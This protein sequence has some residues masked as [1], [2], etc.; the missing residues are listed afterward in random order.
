MKFHLR[1]GTVM[2]Q[3]NYKVICKYPRNGNSRFHVCGVLQSNR[4]KT[5]MPAFRDYFNHYL[6]KEGRRQLNVKTLLDQ[7]F[8]NYKQGL[9]QTLKFVLQTMP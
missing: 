2:L 7:I 9:N 1:V 5:I 6:F 4:L 3:I 8:K